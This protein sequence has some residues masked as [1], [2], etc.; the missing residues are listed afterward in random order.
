MRGLV[1]VLGTL[2][3]YGLRKMSAVV[4]SSFD[5]FGIILASNPR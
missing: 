4:S 1:V 3:I 5:G 2:A